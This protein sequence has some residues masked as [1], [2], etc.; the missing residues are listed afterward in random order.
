MTFVKDLAAALLLLAA[1]S[2]PA[3][4]LYRC[5]NSFQDRPC[6][7]GPQQELKR[8]IKAAPAPASETAASASPASTSAS[9]AAMYGP[10]CSR[11]GEHAQRMSWKREGGATLDKQLAELPPGA[12]PEE[13]AAVARWVYARRGSATD[14][15]KAIEAECIQRKHAAAQAAET[16]QALR[17][18]AG[19]API[20]A[21]PA[22]S[23]AA[24]A[25]DGATASAPATTARAAP[26]PP[27]NASRCSA[28]ASER[29]ELESR[30]RQGGTAQTMEY[31]QNKRRDVEGR[32]S[33]AN[34]R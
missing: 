23:R 24:P 12:D 32:M 9:A 20:D 19:Q 8:P 16:L 30:L 15:R 31:L 18:Q 14:I 22:A 6:E 25:A 1:A 5:G 4:A 2:Q 26:A 17:R 27:S 33:Q 21:P 7:A 13:M 34:C 29:S 3:W 11:I 10:A 28:L